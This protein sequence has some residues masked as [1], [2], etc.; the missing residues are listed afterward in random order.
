MNEKM[1]KSQFS[2]ILQ[3]YP[4]W[5]SKQLSTTFINST[6]LKV[7]K[8]PALLGMLFTTL[9]LKQVL[10]HLAGSAGRAYSS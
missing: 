7:R 1:T 4:L 3:S 9:K 8:S 5:E 6:F 2:R 10:G